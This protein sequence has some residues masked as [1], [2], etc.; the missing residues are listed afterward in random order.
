MTIKLFVEC[1]SSK[2]IDLIFLYEIKPL[3]I[4]IKTIKDNKIDIIPGIINA[5]RHPKYSTKVP[6]IKAPRP[7]PTPPKIRLYV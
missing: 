6:A 1:F 2:S 5:D 3:K 7:I 4:N